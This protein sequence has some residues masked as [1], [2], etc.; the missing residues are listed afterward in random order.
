MALLDVITYP[1]DILRQ[2]AELIE[3]FDDELRRFA[4][5]MAETMYAAPGIGLAANQVGIPVRVVVIDVRDDEGRTITGL[6]TLVNPR[7]VFSEGEYAGEEGCLSV[8]EEREDVARFQK[9]VVEANDL[10]GNLM[11]YEAEDFLAVVFQHEI[12][13]LDGIL[14][15]D[16]LSSLKRTTI[17]KRL[18][19]LKQQQASNG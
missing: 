10:D 13:H 11:Q 9:V 5:D 6:L 2:K 3:D 4:R 7:I 16:H 8:P 14:F 12:D 19:K 1:D 15:I 18:R 17:K